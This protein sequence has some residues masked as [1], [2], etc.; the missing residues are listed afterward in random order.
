MTAVERL[1]SKLPRNER[2]A[3]DAAAKD[4][5][6]DALVLALRQRRERSTAAWWQALL[7]PTTKLN[8]KVS[9][10]TTIE[11]AEALRKAREEED[12]KIYRAIR[13]RALDGDGMAFI[14]FAL[15]EVAGAVAEHN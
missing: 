11:E 14:A 3:V 5:L 4:E 7:D 15:L 2:A 13:T 1:L 8:L 9:T 12:R 10:M 6:G